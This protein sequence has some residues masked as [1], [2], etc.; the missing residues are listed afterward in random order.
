MFLPNTWQMM[1]KLG[2]MLS[3]LSIAANPENTKKT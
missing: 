3:A 2:L 1:I